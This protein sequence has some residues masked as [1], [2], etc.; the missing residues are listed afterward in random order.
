MSSYSVVIPCCN[1]EEYVDLIYDRLKAVLEPLGDFEIIYIDDG[2]TDR[3]LELVKALSERDDRVKYLSFTRNFGLEAGM[4][5]GFKYASKRWIIQIDADLQSPPETIPDLIAKAEEGYDAVFA[6]RQNRKDGALKI[7]G[8]A[9]QHYLSK[10]VFGIDM[11]QHASTFR[12]IDTRVAKKV[13]QNSETAYL[14]FMPEAVATGLR[15]AFVEV[16]HL[17]REMGES[18]FKLGMSLRS[19]WDLFLGHSLV[20]LSFFMGV[21]ILSLLAL[22]VTNGWFIGLL[23]ILFALGLWIQSMYIGRIVSEV[24]H[25]FIYFVREANIPLDP[26]DDYYE[27][28]R[29]ITDGAKA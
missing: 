22:F 23:C 4:R 10:H 18:K 14:Y 8:S 28:E 29:D 27:F 20:P 21:T 15:Y 3:T 11:P 7:I 16:P 26:R 12:I 2:S 17:P 5:A 6:L 24:T 13:V 1:E 25:R 9:G 19:T